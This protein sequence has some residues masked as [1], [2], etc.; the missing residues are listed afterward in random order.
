MCI[1]NV[2]PL[3]VRA[4][5]TFTMSRSCL[6][7]A[8]LKPKTPPGLGIVLTQDALDTLLVTAAQGII[9]NRVALIEFLR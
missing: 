8:A 9:N 2:D 6:A 3:D 4:E 1:L 7:L 5:H